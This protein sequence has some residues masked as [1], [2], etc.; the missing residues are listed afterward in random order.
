MIFDR[1]EAGYGKSRFVLDGWLSDVIGF[2][3]NKGELLH[4]SFTLKS[5]RFVLDELMAFNAAGASAAGGAAHTSGAGQTT[6]VIL[7][8]TD[9]DVAFHADVKQVDYNGMP[10]SLQGRPQNHNCQ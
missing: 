7:V 4:G 6:G 10:R 8:P 2:M 5:E 3:A 9:L 1:F